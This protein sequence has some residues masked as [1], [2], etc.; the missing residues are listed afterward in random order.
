MT[1]DSSVLLAVLFAEP[2]MAWAEAQLQAAAGRLVMSTVNLSEVLIRLKDRRVPDYSEVE[3]ALLNSGI[4]FIPPDVH[5]ARIAAQARL[6]F[7][8][9]LGDCF[10]YALA[11]TMDCPILTLDR[12]FRATDAATVS[13]P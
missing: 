4:Q 1:V 9:N 8:L 2:Q 12:D 13:P 6:D 7:P 10:A 11:K 3:A 5:Q